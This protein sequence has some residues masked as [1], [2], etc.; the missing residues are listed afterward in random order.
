[1][2]TAEVPLPEGI[3][4][5]QVTQLLGEITAS[6]TAAARV[7]AVLQR[8]ES[9]PGP[10]VAAQLAATEQVWR[11]LIERYGAYTSAEVASIRGSNP[12]NRSVATK[13]AMSH[14]IIGF[15]RGSA[16]LYPRFQF[17]GADP[18]PAWRTIVSP[19]REAGWADDDILLWLVSPHAQLGSRE[20]AE[21]LVAD[22]VEELLAL[23]QNEARGVW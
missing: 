22:R 10:G 6:R 13:L 17:A 2:S 11:H 21:L 9:A 7:A 14:G 19:L 5:A 8:E 20:P 3:T 1:M 18:H 12:K 23:V 15:R 4:A 16:K